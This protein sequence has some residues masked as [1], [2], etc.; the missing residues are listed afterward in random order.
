M[1]Q[2][3]IHFQLIQF[4]PIIQFNMNLIFKENVI[5]LIMCIALCFFFEVN[6]V[7]YV[8]EA[9]TFPHCTT[10]QARANIS[11]RYSM[12]AKNKEGVWKNINYHSI[13]FFS[14]ELKTS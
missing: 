7:Q 11:S 13:I 10:I 12:G 9:K 8:E 14:I 6:G 4:E 2:T 3:V 5:A 1:N